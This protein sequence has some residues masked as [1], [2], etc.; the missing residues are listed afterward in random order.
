MKSQNKFYLFFTLYIIPGL[1]WFITLGF[2][3]FNS[4]LSSFGEKLPYQKPCLILSIVLTFIATIIYVLITKHWNKKE[5]EL[6]E[7]IINTGISQIDNLTPFEFEEWI[8]RFLR[9]A[10][11]R[12]YATKKTGDYGVDVI[13]E[14]YNT[15]IAVQVKKFSK[16]VG[17]KAVQEVISG[18]DYY[19]CYEGWVVTTAPNFTQAAKNLAKTRNVKLYNKNDLALILNQLQQE[20]NKD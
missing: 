13:A 17:I 5:V 14:N 15:K 6:Q 7:A 19:N 10:G 11:Y 20:H 9:I 2:L 18:M 4:I 3:M 12:A 1:S 8:A 16:P